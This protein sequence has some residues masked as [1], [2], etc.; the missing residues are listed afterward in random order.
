VRLCT[1]GADCA[2]DT[3][4]PDCCTSTGS[5][6]HVCMSALVKAFTGATDCIP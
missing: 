4:N 3:A 5:D 2:S 1:K 6:Q